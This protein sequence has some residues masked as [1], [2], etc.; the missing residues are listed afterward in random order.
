VRV[1]RRDLRANDRARAESR[2]DGSIRIVTARGRVVGAS[3]LAPGA[4]E[5]IGELTLAV[6]RRARLSSLAS[7]IHVYPAI[8]TGVQQLA[9]DAALRGV[10][11][12][13]GALRMRSRLARR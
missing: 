11:P 2:T 4:G 1:W 3:V 12:L 9:G 6:E 7:T 8:A 10:R 5:L 13:R